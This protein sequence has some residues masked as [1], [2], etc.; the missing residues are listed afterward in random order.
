MNFLYVGQN[1]VGSYDDK[2][3]A[4]ELRLLGLSRGAEIGAAIAVELQGQVYAPLHDHI[5]N[6]TALVDAK[7]GKG[8][9]FYRYTAFGEESLRDAEGNEIEVSANPWRFSSKRLDIEF[10]FI[11]FGKA[12]LRACNRPLD[13]AGSNRTK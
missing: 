12:C 7:T 3:V 10:G 1:E 8:V 13:Y 11:Y 9:E 6:V 5:G 4:L 2:G